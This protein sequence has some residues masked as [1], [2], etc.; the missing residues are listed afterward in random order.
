MIVAR[1]AV[2]LRNA[3]QNGQ[4]PPIDFKKQWV[5]LFFAGIGQAFQDRF[6]Q[7]TAAKVAARTKQA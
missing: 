2:T 1:D 7:S 5:V 6:E 4:P 3:W